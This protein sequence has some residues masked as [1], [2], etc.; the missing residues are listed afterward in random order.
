MSEIPFCQTKFG[1]QAKTHPNPTPPFSEALN[2]NTAS[3]TSSSRDTRDGTPLDDSNF[4]W[5]VGYEST[6][7]YEKRAYRPNTVKMRK[8][9]KHSNV[10]YCIVHNV[11]KTC[12]PT[13]TVLPVL[14]VLSVFM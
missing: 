11:H 8:L 2:D 12:Q 1:I 6:G 3:V 7:I 9:S 10:Y 5:Q 4:S 14:Y 13:H